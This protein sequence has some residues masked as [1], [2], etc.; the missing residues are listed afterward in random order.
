MPRNKQSE[1]QDGKCSFLSFATFVAFCSFEF[2]LTVIKPL[3]KLT[4]S[5]S[6]RIK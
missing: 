4:I 5:K 6:G 3:E 2:A 1:L